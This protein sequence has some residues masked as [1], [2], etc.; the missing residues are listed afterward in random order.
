M[1]VDGNSGW[2]S[3]DVGDV[4]NSSESLIHQRNQ[5][6]PILNACLVAA[7][8]NEKGAV[9]TV[10]GVSPCRAVASKTSG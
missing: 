3:R 1:L 6:V 9:L 7:C 10:D 2:L 4:A 8:L 5:R